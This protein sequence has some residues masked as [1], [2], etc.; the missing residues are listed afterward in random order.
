MEPNFIVHGSTILMKL[1]KYYCSNISRICVIFKLM[2]K[3]VRREG[4]G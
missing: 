2:D 1:I 3:V 4:L